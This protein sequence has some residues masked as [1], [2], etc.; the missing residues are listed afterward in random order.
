MSENFLREN[1]GKFSPGFSCIF[2]GWNS[3]YSRNFV[4]LKIKNTG[5]FDEFREEIFGKFRE[6]FP[7][8][9]RE[10]FPE[11]FC[12]FLMKTYVIALILAFKKQ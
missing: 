4:V 12:V 10:I 3:C 9:H 8:K 5:N 7:E 1:S 11:F 6:I 2:R